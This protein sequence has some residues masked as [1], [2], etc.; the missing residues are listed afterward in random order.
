MGGAGGLV[1]VV[2]VNVDVIWEEG[3]G[4]VLECSLAIREGQEGHE[5]MAKLILKWLPFYVHFYG[6]GVP[7]RFEL[8]HHV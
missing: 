3:W 1:G 4:N 6:F 5:L 8:S 2:G 7:Q